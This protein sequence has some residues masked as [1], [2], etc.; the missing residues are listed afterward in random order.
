M[1]SKSEYT[2]YVRPLDSETNRIIAPQLSEEKICEV[3]I[4]GKS[5]KLWQCTRDDINSFK[6]SQ[7]ALG[8]K[9][10]VYNRQGN[11]QIREC[12]VF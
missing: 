1:E 3:T 6:R 2:W 9:F 5:V 7:E 4:N 12:T 10:K 8:L 11:G